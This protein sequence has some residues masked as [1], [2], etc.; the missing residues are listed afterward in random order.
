[1]CTI[2]L[3]SSPY[4]FIFSTH[5]HCS[6][7]P[8]IVHI[9]LLHSLFNQNPFTVHVYC[10]TFKRTPSPFSFITGTISSTCTVHARVLIHYYFILLLLHYY[11]KHVYCSR[12]SF[13]LLCSLFNLAL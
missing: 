6:P 5:I 2:H 3:L 11:F 1:M 10:L 12:F 7:S 4:L 13:S 9:L 8:F